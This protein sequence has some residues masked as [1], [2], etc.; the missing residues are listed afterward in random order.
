MALCAEWPEV[1]HRLKGVLSGDE[2][3]TWLLHNVQ[4][5]FAHLRGG[6]EV[7]MRFEDDGEDD[8]LVREWVGEREP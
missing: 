1:R 2:V 8:K 7:V 6:T 3:Q 4:R 5:G